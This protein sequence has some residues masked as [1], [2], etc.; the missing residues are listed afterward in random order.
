V[1]HHENLVE[2][3]S[4]C[5]R[6][7]QG[8]GDFVYIYRADLHKAIYTQPASGY[9]T[10]TWVGSWWLVVLDQTLVLGSL[11]CSA[12]HVFFRSTNERTFVHHGLPGGWGFYSV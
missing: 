6:P 5:R 1:H 8:R 4:G 10:F 7:E 12:G 9:V 2:M 3:I 11:S